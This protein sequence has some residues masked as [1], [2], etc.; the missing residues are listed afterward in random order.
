MLHLL[1]TP[2]RD[3]WTG[4]NVFQYI[5]F[6]AAGAA[7]TA[8]VIT[9]LLARVIIPW[10]RGMQF[11]QTIRTDGPASHLSK[12]GTP[13]MGGVLILGATLLSVLLWVRWDNR[14]VYYVLAILLGYGVL[15]FIDDWLNVR[16]KEADGVRARSKLLVQFVLAALV[17]GAIMMDPD[18]RTTFYVPFVKDPLFDLGLLYLPFAMIV[19]VGASNAV[20]LTDGLDGLA[21]G[22]S[23][24]VL[25]TYA[26][27]A[28]TAGHIRIAEYLQ[29]PFSP[30]AG[31]LSVI[32]A[33]LLGA[34]MGFL[35]YNAYPAEVFMGDVGSL[36]LGGV[37]GTLAVLVK[38]ELL[39]A[40]V[41]GVFVAEAV[42]VM[43]QVAVYKRTGRRVFRMA[44][45][46]HHFELLGWAESKV[47]IRFWII[48]LV[49]GIAGLATL[50]LR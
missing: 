11:A 14:Y 12:Q 29:V 5:T 25:A 7:I 4:F 17:A 49:L 13:T 23:M 24:V 15:G 37:I 19:M 46:H 34:G 18:Y 45:L 9:W 50:K 47:V 27:F 39:L 31:E 2:F 48:A 42:S 30:Q 35:W 22:V 40:L 3:V 6:R 41:G 1:L 26:I 32:I 20:N 28:Y 10:L 36:A 44:P 33:A 8:L 16:R 38:Q 21:V 43:V